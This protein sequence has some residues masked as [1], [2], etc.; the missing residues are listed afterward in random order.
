MTSSKIFVH[1][2]YWI[3]WLSREREV[4]W[5]RKLH[6]WIRSKILR[7]KMTSWK[8]FGYT[9]FWTLTLTWI[10]PEPRVLGDENAIIGFA[11]KFWVGKCRHRQFLATPTFWTLTWI[12]PEPKIAWWRNMEHKV[13]KSRILTLIS[14]TQLEK[15]AF[16]LYVRTTDARIRHRQKAYGP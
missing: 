8:I 6:G 10:L 1:A 15:A 11:V 7:P 4:A 13:R 5:W 3:A 2:H 16:Y 9:N 14:I 12:S